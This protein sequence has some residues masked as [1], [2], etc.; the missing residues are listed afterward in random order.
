MRRRTSARI[1]LAACGMILLLTGCLTPTVPKSVR[2]ELT[3]GLTFKTVLADP[4]A[5]KGGTVMWA[6]EVLTLTAETNATRLEILEVPANACGE[7]QARDRSEGRFLVRFNEYLDAA[8]YHRGQRVTVVGKV[9]GRRRQPLGPELVEYAYPELKGEHIYLWSRPPEQHVYYH[10]YWD[11]PW[12]WDPWYGPYY[13]F[14]GE[15]VIIRERREAPARH[16]RL[17]MHEHKR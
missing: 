8:I 12:Y 9:E 15:E 17:E 10:N 6:G 5:F 11:N 14:F 1:G 13:P 16:E 4:D 7:P 3:P 2:Q